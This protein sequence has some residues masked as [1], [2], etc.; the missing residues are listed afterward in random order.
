LIAPWTAE[1]QLAEG[2]EIVSL[3]A[4][5]GD[6]ERLFD[7]HDHSFW[8]AWELGDAVRRAAELD[9]MTRVAGELRQPA[10]HWALATAQAVLALSQGRFF[11]AL[12]L[13]DQAAA[14]GERVLTWGAV[15]ARK[16]QLFLLLREQ[17]RLQGFERELVGCE[18]EF[19][20]PLVHGAVLAHVY[21]RGERPEEAQA[22][23]QELT[24]RDLSDWHVDEEWL[25]GIC[26]L[27]ETCA[28]LEDTPHAAPLYELLLPYVSLNA[29]AVPE[30]TLGSASRPL[31]LLA[32]QL[33]RFDDAAGHLEEAIQMNERMGARPALAHTQADLGRMLLRRNS[34]GDE[35]R[36][37]EHLSR[38]LATYH[39]LD[40]Q[41]DA[42]N[43]SRTLA[44]VSRPRS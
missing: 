17:G 10:Q 9:S 22:L 35:Q 11:E 3:A 39:E 27:A 41:P 31:G 33:G 21:A 30:L 5:T 15:A 1:R 4:R 24:R 19:P 37:H 12:E 8:A 16:L 6:R 25:F 34:Q 7:G 38:A 28:I 40:M 32:A 23:L 13:I 14:V 43:T 44:S 29:V 42:A 26:L 20:S 36:A 18:G 2:S